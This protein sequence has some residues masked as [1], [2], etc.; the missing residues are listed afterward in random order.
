MHR[1]L[2]RWLQLSR[3]ALSPAEAGDVGR[4]ARHP[5]V[6]RVREELLRLG[7][8]ER[9]RFVWSA[10]GSGVEEEDPR[11]IHLH[12]ALTRAAGAPAPV[13]AAAERALALDLA[14]VLRHEL[15]HALLF[16]RPRPAHTGEFRR[17][18]G[19]VDVTYRVGN[20]VDEVMRRIDAHGGLDNPRYRRVVSLYAATHPHERFAEA[21][22]VALRCG[23]DEVALRR[24]T[25][26]HG[27]APVVARQLAWAAR[28]LRG[29]SRC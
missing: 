12:R 4:P 1:D 28:W 6:D 11:V 21:V 17:L 27:A 23:A 29:W 5:E 25:E 14:S 2:T 24:W 13:R 18:F 7:V 10:D 26:A 16:L 3:G 9:F 8:K 20:P 15:G 19:D 22:R